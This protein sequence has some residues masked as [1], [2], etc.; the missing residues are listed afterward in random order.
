[1]G[2][3]TQR[4]A[5]SACGKSLGKRSFSDFEVR[6]N[7]RLFYVTVSHSAGCVDLGEPRKVISWIMS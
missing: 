6:P 7:I 3:S 1:M 2:A 4:A 5:A